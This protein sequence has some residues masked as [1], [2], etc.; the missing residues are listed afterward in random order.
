ME[1]VLRELTEFELDTVSGGAS[2]AAASGTT[3]AGAVGNFGAVT[4]DGL[5]VVVAGLL[6]TGGGITVTSPAGA[7]AI[8]IGA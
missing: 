2:A 6:F 7:A 3:A 4:T 8:G 5:S 1:E